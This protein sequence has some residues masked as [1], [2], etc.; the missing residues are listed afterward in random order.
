[1][2][3]ITRY[4][5]F[6]I[7]EPIIRDFDRFS[8]V[9]TW[10]FFAP[11]SV[12]PLWQDL[13]EWPQRLG[14]SVLGDNLPV[15]MLERES[16][17]IIKA[18]LPFVRPEEVTVE[19]HDGWLTI[20]AEHQDQREES[21]TGWYIRERFAG[22]WQRSLCLP[23]GVQAE[24]ADAALEDGILT[25]RLPKKTASKPFVHIPVKLPKLRLPALTKK[26]SKV[27]VKTS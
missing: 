16:E 2:T 23:K 6:D 11:F 15:D 1:M 24:K 17:V 14:A 20:R 25:I 3:N 5:P 7:V 18:D 12:D 4:K 8:P 19:E 13:L 10:P 22:A 27:T 9:S 21:R 26:R